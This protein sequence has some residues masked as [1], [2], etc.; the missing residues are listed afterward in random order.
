M[1]LVRA[2]ELDFKPLQ[3]NVKMLK[4]QD[5][6]VSKIILHEY[7]NQEYGQND[8]ALILLTKPFDLQ[9]NIGT[10][11]LPP[12]GYHVNNTRCKTTDWV[13]NDVGKFI[14]IILCNNK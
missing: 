10:I 1:L 12:Q 5:R 2:G 13:A 3:M 7:Y 14:H 9:R 11:C 6:R 4:Y 8:I